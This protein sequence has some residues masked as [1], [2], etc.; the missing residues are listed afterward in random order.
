MSLLFQ[1]RNSPQFISLWLFN[2]ILLPPSDATH[3]LS[4]L[5][6]GSGRFQ[7]KGIPICH[8]LTTCS[9]EDA[10]CVVYGYLL[11]A[12]EEV[13]GHSSVC[14]QQHRQQKPSKSR[15][16]N[17]KQTQTHK[18]LWSWKWTPFATIHSLWILFQNALNKILFQNAKNELNKP[19]FLPFSFNR[20]HFIPS[21]HLRELCSW[22]WQCTEIWI[23]TRLCM[24]AEHYATFWT[25][26]H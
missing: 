1:L 11:P 5:E 8:S 7:G 9:E 2:P 17:V 12:C 6:R 3:I 19:N 10:N 18:K 24:Y 22:K 14:H 20:T 13:N 26:Q 21:F 15:R 16:Y 23:L 4:G 25:K